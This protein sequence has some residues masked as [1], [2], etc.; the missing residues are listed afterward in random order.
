MGFNF[1]NPDWSEFFSG[2]AT[3]GDRIKELLSW[4]FSEFTSIP[5]PDVQPHSFMFL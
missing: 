4:N 1:I 2:F 5:S 3:L